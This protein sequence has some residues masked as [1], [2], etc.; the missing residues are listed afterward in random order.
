M[1]VDEENPNDRQP[2][3]WK[4]RWWWALFGTAIVLRLL[5]T[6]G[7]ASDLRVAEPILDGRHYL[8]LAGRLANG[9]GWPAGPI[10]MSPLYPWVLGLLFRLTGATPLAAQ[11]FQAGLG[12][13][14]LALLYLAARRDLG[15]RAGLAL[16]AL[17]VLCGPVL[18]RE[19]QVLAEPLLLFLTAAALWCWPKPG[20]PR[21]RYLL[22]GV[23]AGL[24]VTG[25]GVFL[26][27]PLAAAIHY[28]LASRSHREQAMQE[29]PPRAH[30]RRSK[31]KA[32][33]ARPAAPKRFAWVAG[34]LGRPRTSAG[35]RGNP[36]RVPTTMAGL[37][38][39]ALGVLL[40]MLPLAVRQTRSTGSLHFLP[41]NGGLNFY[42]GNRAA[43]EGTYNLPPEIDL[44]GDITAPHAASKLAGKTLTLEE[45]SRFWTRRA[46]ADL[47]ASPGRW[48]ALWTK[49]ALLFFSPREIPQIE[50]F[51]ILRQHHLPLRFAIVDFAWLLPLA[52]LGVVAHLRSRRKSQA[53]S[54]AERPAQALAP[55]LIVVGIGWLSTIV[56]FV[57]GRYRLPFLAGFFGPAA[58]GLL[59]LVDAIR[60]RRWRLALVALPLAVVVQWLLPSY[61]V[62]KA[63]ASDHD[64]MAL[65]L[66]RRNDADGALAEYRKATQLDPQDGLA[67]HGIGAVH[68]HMKRLPEAAEAYREALKHIPSSALTHYNLGVV[69]GRMGQDS[70]ALPELKEAVRLDPYDPRFQADMAVALARLGNKEEAEK[71]ARKLLDQKPGFRP[72]LRLLKQMGKTP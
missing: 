70:A 71:I 21:W 36:S 41:L 60:A 20:Q 34:R 65:R 61:P 56:F 4:N 57:S 31:G 39:V 33:R 11:I 68:V 46:L 72:A 15:A 62:A 3:T 55:W 63:R 47:A 67:W 26:L 48:L 6:A 66:R 1:S 14:T 35:G 24:L 38:F 49:K 27:L 8:E 10:S 23:I 16:A 52:V 54:P 25:R 29:Q 64:Q 53:A 59:V 40:T 19:S 37:S 22:F 9:Q 13:C 12:L 58:L 28:W 43:A 2:S 17:Y 69:L 44:E 45:S 50:D 18:G 51:Q 42:I 32:P 5:S 7:L 30:Q